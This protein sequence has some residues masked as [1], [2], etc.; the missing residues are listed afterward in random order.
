VVAWLDVLTHM[1]K[2]NP[3]VEP[4]IYTPGLARTQLAMQPQPALGGSRVM[5]LPTAEAGL[6]AFTMSNPGTNFLIKRLG[7]FADC[8]LL[9]DV[10]KVNGF[11]SLYPRECGELNSIIYSSTNAAFPRL[12]DF[13]AASHITA[14]DR[15]FDWV[16]RE[17]F[18]P[19]ITGGQ[20][21]IY[22]EDAQALQA[23]LSRDFKPNDVVMLPPGAQFQATNQAPVRLGAARFTP[24]SVEFEAEAGQPSLV[25]VAQTFY[26][27]WSA[28]IDGQ[29]AR[30]VRANYAFQALEIPAGRHAIRMVYAEK[31]LPAGILISLA[32]LIACGFL[33]LRKS[34]NMV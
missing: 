21:P 17:G 26:H 6:T 23:I 24:R 15:F 13:M 5:V 11:F 14:A 16:P 33:W 1:P 2:Q 10:P 20:R 29:P 31:T 8:N 22:L 9:D 4:W 27:G 18:L 34:N 30:V 28:K 19:L 12:A 3:T 25:T 7:Y 32:A